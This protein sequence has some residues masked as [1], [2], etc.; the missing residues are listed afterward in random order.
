M[1]HMSMDILNLLEGCGGVGGAC[2]RRF[3]R[4]S[5]Y[6]W[7]RKGLLRSGHKTA[8]PRCVGTHLSL[9]FAPC[10]PATPAATMQTAMAQ[11]L[12]LSSAPAAAVRKAGARRLPALRVATTTRC[13]AVSRRG[14]L[15][16]VRRLAAGAG[17]ARAVMAQSLARRHHTHLRHPHTALA[18]ALPHRSPPRLMRL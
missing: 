10:T 14:A 18:P 13:Q 15:C 8:L 4:W 17:G 16:S 7:R 3:G 6:H 2:R 5:G 12:S 11:K 1:K 9:S